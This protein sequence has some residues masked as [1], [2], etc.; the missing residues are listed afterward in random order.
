[1]SD[2]NLLSLISSMN[3]SILNMQNNY[4]L[5]KTGFFCICICS[6]VSLGVN[7]ANTL[8]LIENNKSIKED[9]YAMLNE[10]V[11]YLFSENEKLVSF[12]KAH[13]KELFV[14]EKERANF[15]REK[16]EFSM[17]KENFIKEL[18]KRENE[19]ESRTDSPITIGS[20]LSKIQ[21]NSFE[22]ELDTECYDNI[23]MSNAK[24]I[25]RNNWF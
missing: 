24:K 21:N 22:M 12:L 3:E 5:F 2:K 7:I 9:E 19:K 13:K 4:P 15:E 17:L 23:P 18:E 20:Y 14:L 16:I 11:N 25:T 8:A 6:V 10:R 1:M